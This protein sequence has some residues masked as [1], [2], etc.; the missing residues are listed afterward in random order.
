MT[1]EDKFPN[2]HPIK[3]YLETD[4]EWELLRESTKVQIKEAKLK[5]YVYGLDPMPSGLELDIDSF[6]ENFFYR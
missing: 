3:D 6:Y 2:A 1:S 5:R 4:W